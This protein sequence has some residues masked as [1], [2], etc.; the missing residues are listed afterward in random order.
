MNEK[1]TMVQKDASFPQKRPKSKV[2]REDKIC[3][4]LHE[5]TNH[6]G[7]QMVIFDFDGTL[8]N[9]NDIIIASW[10]ATF[11]R[12]LGYSPAVREIEATFGEILVHTIGKLMPDAPVNEVVD[13]YRAYQDSHQKDYEVYVFEGV[14]ELLEQ[15][16]E[17]GC[18]IGVGTSRTSY[19]FW[20]Y[21]LIIRCYYI[22]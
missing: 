10:K 5:N 20:N 13:Y 15:L 16:R 9:T 11:E 2:I 4:M 12:Y 22:R 21:I 19:S 17:R 14:K 3:E 18:L 6:R 7:I 8:A 1:L